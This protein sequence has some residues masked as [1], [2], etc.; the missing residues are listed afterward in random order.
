M[1]RVEFERLRDVPNK[2]ITADIVFQTENPE[3]FSFADVQVANELG[4][5]LILNGRYKPN[6][7]AV[8]FNFYVRGVG[9]ICRIEVNSTMHGA[10]GRTHKHD[11]QQE[12]C[13]RRNLPHAIP[14]PDLEPMAIQEVWATICEQARIIHRGK[15]IGPE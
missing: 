14:R 1:N 6:L 5:D 3:T 11:L 15:L 4:V 7:P 12:S 8:K 13:P 9:P 10:A 2:E